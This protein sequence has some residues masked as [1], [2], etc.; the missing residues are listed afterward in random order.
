MRTEAELRDKLQRLEMQQQ[1]YERE[2]SEARRAVRKI[3]DLQQRLQESEDRVV[4]AAQEASM[5][6][7]RVTA[8][9]QDFEA[10][11]RHLQIIEMK[12]NILESAANI[13]D[14]RL[15]S[16]ASSSTDRP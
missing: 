12:L 16:D 1:L 11:R 7:A 14:Q 10:S 2:R 15:R 13:L 6:E 8:A 3:E 9:V 4:S 5:L